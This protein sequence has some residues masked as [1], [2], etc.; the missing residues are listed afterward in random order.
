MYFNR[1]FLPASATPARCNQP[2]NPLHTC[3]RTPVVMHLTL[4]FAVSQQVLKAFSDNDEK[5][6]VDLVGE[7][8]CACVSLSS[9]ENSTLLCVAGVEMS[10]FVQ[11]C[12]S[13]GG[14]EVN[15]SPQTDVQSE[16]C[17]PRP[18]LPTP[19]SPLSMRY[20]RTSL[21]PASTA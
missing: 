3:C 15:A 2:H 11:R 5:E 6:P 18:A 9:L 13:S 7:R 12:C 1:C 17:V 16:H 21:P 10:F 19:S 14:A 20:L 4:C 8:V